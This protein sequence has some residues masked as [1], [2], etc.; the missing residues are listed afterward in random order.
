ME[1]FR[2]KF[3]SFVEL[4]M[5]KFA[6]VVDE[7]KSSVLALGFPRIPTVEGT[8]LTKDSIDRVPVIV[9]TGFQASVG[10]IATCGHVVASLAPHPTYGE[11]RIISVDRENRYIRFWAFR[12]ALQ[13]YIHADNRVDES[14]D[15]GLIVMLPK[16]N[17]PYPTTPVRWGDSDKVRVGE[18]V[19]ICGFP[20]GADL[21]I[22]SQNKKVTGFG[23][24]VQRGIISAILP[25][26]H[27][28][29]AREL[30]QLD[31]QTYGG[32][33]GGPVFLAETGEVIGMIVSALEEGGTVT[34]ITYALPGNI[35][36]D[37]AS[38]LSF[39][40]SRGIKY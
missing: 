11:A 9:G 40:D 30:F 23:Y 39:T 26:E 20:M 37:F 10:K 36:K 17:S 38:R 12:Q 13:K 18:E 2:K 27:P 32:M 33:S 7:V 24:T 21:F 8:P 3:D 29:V 14:I 16:E 4:A 34:N 35:V 31:I 1:R 5:A 6:D 19:G 15:C 22:D 28:S 25:L